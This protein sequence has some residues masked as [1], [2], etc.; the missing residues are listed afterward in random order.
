[1]VSLMA[2]SRTYEIDSSRSSW[3]LH[4]G[5]AEVGGEL[6]ELSGNLVF[7]SEDV[8]ACS[9]HLWSAIAGNG[10]SSG[11]SNECGIRFVSWR[12]REIGYRD[13]WVP[14]ALRIGDLAQVESLRLRGPSAE[15]ADTHG[16]LRAAATA[17]AKIG[18]SR[19]PLAMDPMQQTRDH[20]PRAEAILCFQIELVCRM[21][22]ESKSVAA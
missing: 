5:D 8:N 6:R 12:F 13:Y 17:V 10:D 4:V 9:I 15:I 2:L 14:G 21:P 19:I 16:S 1:M 3:K 20:A 7:D 11:T 18:T 22:A